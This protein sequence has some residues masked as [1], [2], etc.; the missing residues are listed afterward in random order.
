MKTPVEA[1]MEQEIKLNKAI[2]DFEEWLYATLFN[3]VSHR[4]ASIP[5]QDITQ[6][7]KNILKDYELMS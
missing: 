4:G 7:L 2:S 5:V 1:E 6:K 3:A